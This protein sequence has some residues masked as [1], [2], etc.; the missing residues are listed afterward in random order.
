MVEGYRP[1]HWKVVCDQ[2]GAQ[3][4]NDQVRR[5]HDGLLV[6]TQSYDP[7]HPQERIRVRPEYGAVFPAR[8]IPEPQYVA[9]PYV[10]ESEDDLILEA[11]A[12]EGVMLQ[13]ETA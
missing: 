11:E 9:L 5:Q 10:L 3:V 13:S 7:Q 2:T 1:G 6:R 8:P 4:W 12:G